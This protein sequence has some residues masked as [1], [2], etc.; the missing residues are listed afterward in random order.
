MITGVLIGLS[1]FT[2]LFVSGGIPFTAA[3]FILSAG[4]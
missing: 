2:L 1:K 4:N 3:H